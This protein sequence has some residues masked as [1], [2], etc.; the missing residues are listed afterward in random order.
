MI[1]EALT[2]RSSV[3][4]QGLLP[5]DQ[6][7]RRHRLALLRCVNGNGFAVIEM[8]QQRRPGAGV[9]ARV[10][11]GHLRADVGQ[12]V[13]RKP[14]PPNRV[15]SGN[16]SESG[17]QRHAGLPHRSSIRTTNSRRGS[18]RRQAPFTASFVHGQPRVRADSALTASST[19][20]ASSPSASSSPR[21][22]GGSACSAPASTCRP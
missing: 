1:A 8:V 15:L 9:D 17:Q 20:G 21:S 18:W 4:P 14:R 3:T 7:C 6:I 22:A 19:A 10:D 13:D 11:A 5:H 2:C 12:Q 16:H